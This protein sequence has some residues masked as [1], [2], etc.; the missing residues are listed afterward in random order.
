[1][2]FSNLLIITLFTLT[3]SLFT[4]IESITINTELF[5]DGEKLESSPWIIDCIDS[6]IKYSDLTK[7]RFCILNNKT[8]GEI[9]NLV[10]KTIE[11]HVST[12]GMISIKTFK[13]EKNYNGY[14]MIVFLKYDQMNGRAITMIDSLN[15]YPVMNTKNASSHAILFER[16]EFIGPID[17]YS[18][19]SPM[20]LLL[21]LCI[22]CACMCIGM[23]HYKKKREQY[24]RK[25]NCMSPNDAIKSEPQQVFMDNPYQLHPYIEMNPIVNGEKNI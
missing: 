23:C 3:C 24:K 16:H 9:Q 18:L 17:Q 11:F 5:V 10:N 19:V 2:Q 15:I 22:G 25:I 8:F 14:S 7:E 4:S 20:F 12:I 13:W 1:M 6:Q 21:I